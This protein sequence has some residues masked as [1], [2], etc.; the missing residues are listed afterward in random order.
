MDSTEKKGK[1]DK[2]TDAPLR[3][4]DLPSRAAG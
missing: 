4:V 2:P 3:R 1:R